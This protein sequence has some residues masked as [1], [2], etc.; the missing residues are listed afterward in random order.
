MCKEFYMLVFRGSASN[1]NSSSDSFY[2]LV[3]S[4]VEDQNIWFYIFATKECLI[5][6]SS[7][8][9]RRVYFLFLNKLLEML[10]ITGV[11][12]YH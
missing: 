3:N 4:S 11:Y 2:K 7:A 10:L 12:L 5:L 9:N 1:R 8:N 6:N